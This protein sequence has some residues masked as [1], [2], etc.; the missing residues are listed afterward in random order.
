MI[1]YFYK[2]DLVV[3]HTQNFDQ[4]EGKLIWVDLVNPTKQEE[5]FVENKFG[6]EL[7]TDHESQEIEMSSKFVENDSE[8]GANINFMVREGESHKYDP[9][10][11]ILYKDILFTE[12][13]KEFVSF[14]DVY[15][16]LHNHQVQNG[17]DV[18]I[19]ILETRIDYLADYVEEIT[20]KIAQ[21]KNELMQSNKFD[22]SNFIKVADLQSKSMAVREN[23][24]EFQRTLSA[25]Q[26]SKLFPKN[27]KDDVDIMAHDLDSL[28]EHIQFNFGRLESLQDTYKSLIDFEQNRIMKFFTIISVIFLPPT[29]IA[30]L[31]GMNFQNMPETTLPWGYYY[32]IF[33]MLFS[34][35]ISLIIFRWQK[36]I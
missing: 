3:L 20:S 9:V 27:E 32:A 6:I 33:L 23:I 8:V 21:L 30:G 15:K 22:K 1:E 17:N 14:E 12:R 11:F 24:I 25:W 7:F 10:S 5:R 31:Y 2:Q 18:F 35:I 29:F 28:I 34:V 26:R 19:Y 13:D 16:K 4:V 36:W